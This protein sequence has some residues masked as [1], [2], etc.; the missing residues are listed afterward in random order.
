MLV[1]L[2]WS[3]SMVACAAGTSSTSTE[4]TTPGTST[5]ATT[6]GTSTTAPVSASPRPLETLTEPSTPRPEFPDG[7]WDRIYSRQADRCCGGIFETPVRAMPQMRY[8]IDG[9]APTSMAN[10]YVV[11]DVV[12][13]E[14][15]AS[16]RWTFQGEDGDGPEV[17]HEL[18]FNAEDAQ[19]TTV[20]LVVRVERAIVDPDQDDDVH[21]AVSVGSTV[22]LAVFLGAAIDLESVRSELLEQPTRLAA[23]VNE[24]TTLFDYAEDLWAVSM[25]GEYLGRVRD[26]LVEFPAERYEGGPEE[27]EGGFYTQPEGPDGPRVFT[28]PIV[29]LEAPQTGGPEAFTQDPGS[30]WYRPVPGSPASSP[31]AD[32]SESPS[33]DATD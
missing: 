17:M 19:A 23:L 4:A 1:G 30:G 20:H 16:F 15:G 5:Q 27:P 14:P 26:D 32:L 3:L 28:V 24:G 21:E 6:P 2:F 31:A 22:T 11:G 25:D 8:I 7:L 12:A 9:G 13:V 18:D 33:T 10:A 29:V